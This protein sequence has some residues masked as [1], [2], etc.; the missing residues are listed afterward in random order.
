MTENQKLL[1]AI[2]ELDE[3]FISEAAHPYNP[4]VRL[5]FKIGAAAASLIFTFAVVLAA[6]GFSGIMDNAVG[7]DGAGGA[8]P[9]MTDGGDGSTSDIHQESNGTYILYSKDGALAL[10]R[11]EA[12]KFTFRLEISDGHERIDAS[13][14]LKDKDGNTVTASTKDAD[15]LSPKIKVNGE[16][17]DRIPTERGSYT[18]VF[19]LSNLT[20]LGYTVSDKITVSPF[21]D[22]LLTNE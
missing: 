3:K 11:C 17:T 5:I 12:D 7:G 9:P 18:V 8:A 22:F 15:A 13:F 14:I 16:S 6:I 2:S 4:A 21:G 19:D 20:E 10:T 1:Y